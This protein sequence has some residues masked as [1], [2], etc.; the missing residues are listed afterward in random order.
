MSKV[1]LVSVSIF[2]GMPI[3]PVVPVPHPELKDVE[4]FHYN[5]ESALRDAH[6]VEGDMFAFY[7][8]HRYGGSFVD[9][10]LAYGTVCVKGG[11]QLDFADYLIVTKDGWAWLHGGSLTDHLEQKEKERQEALLKERIEACVDLQKFPVEVRKFFYH[12]GLNIN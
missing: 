1:R 2:D 11:Y 8:A 6:A 4:I 10:K 9:K 3:Q 7:S 12:E 5:V